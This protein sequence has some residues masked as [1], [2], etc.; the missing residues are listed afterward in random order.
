MWPRVPGAPA[1][2]PSAPCLHIEGV[3][4][5]GGMFG[6]HVLGWD[7]KAGCGRWCLGECLGV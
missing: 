5:V 3:C 4:V 6:G 1:P 7:R 2:V